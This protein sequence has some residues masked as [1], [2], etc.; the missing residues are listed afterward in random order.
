MDYRRHDADIKCVPARID[1]SHALIYH[2]GGDMH[3]TNGGL[4]DQLAFE[5]ELPIN[6]VAVRDPIVITAL[7][8]L[9][10]RSLETPVCWT[11]KRIVIWCFAAQTSRDI[12]AWRRVSVIP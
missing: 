4:V 11:D 7:T 12:D 3:A 10:I 5:L 1:D 6:L 8:T 2:S 9:R